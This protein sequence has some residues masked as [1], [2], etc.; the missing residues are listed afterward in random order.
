MPDPQTV[1]HE[2]VRAHIN[3]HGGYA[4]FAQARSISQRTAERIFSGTRPAPYWLVQEIREGEK[5][6]G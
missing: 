2:Q 6:H 5:A 1:T 4:S 3:R